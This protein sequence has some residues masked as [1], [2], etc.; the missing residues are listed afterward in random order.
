MR[1]TFLRWFTILVVVGFLLSFSPAKAEF[2][3]TSSSTA[4][5]TWAIQRADDVPF[6]SAEMGDHAAV[7][8]S[9]GKLH[10]VYGGDHLYYAVCVGT[11]CTIQTV[12][13]ADSVG[14]QASLA[15]DSQGHPHIA[16]HDAG[17]EI[18]FCNDWKL[19]YA[20]WDGS[21]WVIQ[22]VDESCTGINPSIGLDALN[23]PHIS[24]FN[25]SSD[26]LQLADWDGNAWNTY[27]PYWL[28]GYDLSGFH[29]SLQSD[30]NGKLHLAFIVN[31]GGSTTIQYANNI[32]GSWSALVPVD[33]QPGV[34]NFA[35]TL[36]NN[37]P[38]FSYHLGYNP[39]G[40]MVYKA[41]YNWFNG[42]TMQT[43]FEVSDMDYLGRTAVAMGTD[44]YP[45][46]AYVSSG[47]VKW[48]AKTGVSTWG[49]AA[50]IPNTANIQRLFLGRSSGSSFGLTFHPGGVVKNT[51]ESSTIW[52][53]PT[54]VAA[55][56]YLGDH[57]SLAAAASGDLHISYTNNNGHQLKYAHRMGDSWLVTTIQTL[58]GN[59]QILATDI[60]LGPSGRPYIVYEEEDASL[61]SVLKYTYWTG[62][63][64]TPPVVVSQPGSYG[65]SPSMEVTTAGE[66]YIAFQ[67][68]DYSN[69]GLWL[70]A[71][72]GS[73]NYSQVEFVN[74][75]KFTAPSLLVN[76][77]TGYISIAYV[78]LD[79]SHPALRYAVK[80]N[81]AS[82]TI[83]TPYDMPSGYVFNPSLA[84]DGSG[85]PRIAFTTSYITDQ[86][87]R[88]AY[89]DGSQWNVDQV[90]GLD[91]DRFETSL[92]V[93]ASNR[94]HL[95]FAYDGLS[96]AVKDGATWTV[97][98]VDYPRLEEGG[99]SIGPV[100]SVALALNNLGKPVI[101]YN[102][103]YDLKVAELSETWKLNLPIVRR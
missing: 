38:H 4:L 41:R 26:D 74:G 63:A 37:N 23:Y 69:E 47:G 6:I 24:Y 34:V 71:Y 97:T 51:T 85:R 77:T 94:P 70:A 62:S 7:Y 44:G 72:N 68:C 73:W 81:T 20:K 88:F 35:M 1:L 30:S 14:S 32:F 36:D 42:S 49:T 55:T 59:N 8:D 52:S 48:R 19:K 95:V 67:K 66:T 50:D 91:N 25:E 61:Y 45:R 96:Y 31:D 53:A 60:D 93:D 103:E 39:G 64:W 76:E 5:A 40:G 89:W 83:T 58:T 79:Y 13:S 86:L 56:E 15:L 28:P 92:V 22:V 100:N 46:V 90:S 98:Q 80:E 18:G 75:E 87:S 3:R 43:P 11:S 101:A 54:T 10:V 65:C 84:M 21:Q 29:S 9:T 2:R 16:Y 12:D 17:L 99:W 27:T 33:T 82:W 78:R 57:I 102:A